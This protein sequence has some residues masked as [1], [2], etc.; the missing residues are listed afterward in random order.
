MNTGSMFDYYD[1]P[2]EYV[3]AHM[4]RPNLAT[5]E[6]HGHFRKFNREKPPK[7]F[8]AKSRQRRKMSK[9]SKRRNRER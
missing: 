9:A 2:Y 1:S 3:M 6:G 4:E 5:G 7:D 8:K